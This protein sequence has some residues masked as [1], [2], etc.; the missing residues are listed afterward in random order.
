MSYRGVLQA[1]LHPWAELCQCTALSG[2]EIDRTREREMAG[3]KRGNETRKKKNGKI[4][5]QKSPKGHSGKSCYSWLCET[6][7]NSLCYLSIF[8]KVKKKISGRFFQG[9][10]IKTKLLQNV[11]QINKSFLIP[12][13]L[14]S[15]CTKIIHDRLCNFLFLTSSQWSHQSNLQWRSHNITIYLSDSRSV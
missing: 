3:G 5:E 11:C 1:T 13:H 15:F 9:A 10:K 12:S 4:K 14:Q 6:C 7:L 2:G 8:M